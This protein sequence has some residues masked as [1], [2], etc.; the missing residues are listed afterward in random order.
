MA[1]LNRTDKVPSDEIL[2]PLNNKHAIIIGFT[3]DPFG[4]IGPAAR[5]MLFGLQDDEEPPDYNPVLPASLSPAA[6]LMIKRATGP[7]TIQGTLRHA[8]QAWRALHGYRWYGA[9]YAESTPSTY[10]KA[11][12]GTT[13]TRALTDHLYRNARKSTTAS[14]RP[15]KTPPA[16]YGGSRWTRQRPTRLSEYSSHSVNPFQIGHFGRPE[17]PMGP[18]APEHP[19]QE[20]L[21]QACT[22]THTDDVDT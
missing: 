21:V 20:T 6:R 14:I 10:A 17:P 16:P 12:L 2:T 9:T 22:I 11:L 19:S 5:R 15:G 1:A 4:S 13:I 8:D 18:H 7:D 3:V